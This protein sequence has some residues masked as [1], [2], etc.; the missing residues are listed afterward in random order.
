VNYSVGG[1]PEIRLFDDRGALRL[2]GEWWLGGPRF[3]TTT[4]DSAWRFAR[5]PSAHHQAVLRIGARLASDD[6]PRGLWPAAGATQARGVLLRAHPLLEA[7]VV[8]GEGFG[9]GLGYATV[10]G[11]RWQRVRGLRIGA[12]AFADAVHVHARDKQPRSR[13]LVDTG[14][15]VRLGFVSR[16]AH[17]RLDLARSLSDGRMALSAAWVAPWPGYDDRDR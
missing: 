9:R 11:Q 12:A 13:V 6:A 1:G 8:S 14:L 7:H 10:E 15:G 17:L 2:D 3:S 5:E 4:V 16:D